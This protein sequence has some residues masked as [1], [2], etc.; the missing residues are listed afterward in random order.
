VKKAKTIRLDTREQRKPLASR[1]APYYV[2]V[3]KGVAVGYRKGTTGSTWS[4]RIFNGRKYHRTEICAADD[5]APADGVTVFDWKS[6]L[7]VALSEPAKADAFKARYSVADAVKDY[8]THRRARSRSLESIATDEG[9]AKAF[10]EKFGSLQVAVLTTGELQDWRDG[11]VSSD[12]DPDLSEAERRDALRASQASANRVWTICRAALNH[13]FR[14]GRVDADLAWRR[15]RPFQ[16]VDKA[17]KRFLSITEANKMLGAAEGKFRD[18]VQASLLTGLRPGEITR[19]TV[20]Q[21]QRTRLEIGAGKT[22][23]MRYVPLT[24]QGVSL[25]KRLSKNRAATEVMLTNAEGKP[26]TKRQYNLA[27]GRA[28]KVAGIKDAVFYDLRRTYGSLLVNAKANTATIAHALGHVDE[29]MT[30]RHYAHLLDSS[31]AVEIQAK[32]PKFKATRAKA[33][34]V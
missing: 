5:T 34:A 16:D 31:V 2:P 15:I 22:D 30:R 29:R 13:S 1:D 27:W 11:L 33:A 32:L 10:T 21:F 28:L 26:W 17:R 3:A 14:A 19:L 8:F 18:L 4:V 23:T 7:K 20:G 25:F 6:V 12:A 24:T 9:K